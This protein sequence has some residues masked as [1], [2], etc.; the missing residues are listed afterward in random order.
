MEELENS[1]QTEREDEEKKDKEK[2]RNLSNSDLASFLLGWLAIFYDKQGVNIGRSTRSNL[3]GYVFDFVHYSKEGREKINDTRDISYW[4]GLEEAKQRIKAEK[5]PHK[6]IELELPS[7]SVEDLSNDKLAS[8]LLYFLLK[9]QEEVDEKKEMAELENLCAEREFIKRATLLL[10]FP[11]F[12]KCPF[13]SLDL[14]QEAQKR[15][16]KRQKADKMI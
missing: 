14:M 9:E 1:R 6:Q 5:I 13:S 12:E 8:G 10:P 16:E 3:L 7:N 11:D 4:A 2:L 15:R